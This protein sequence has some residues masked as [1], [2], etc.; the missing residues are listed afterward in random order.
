MPKYAMV[1]D[2]EKCTGCAACSVTCKNENNVP[3]G[4]FWSHYITETIGEFPNVKYNYITTLCNHCDNAPC[5][6]ACP[7]TPKA[8]T[9]ADNGITMHNAETCIGC[10]ACQ[11]ACPYGVIYYNTEEPFQ[12]WRSGDA[13]A[14]TEKVGGNVIPYY[15]P[16]RAATYAGIRGKLKVEKCTFCDHR[17]VNGEQPYCVDSC[18]AIARIF[19]DISDPDSE[20]SKLLKENEHMV[21]LP[22][23]NTKPNV[24]YIKKFDVK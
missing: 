4:I 13:A 5:V 7:I 10:R 11:V 6:E 24:Y 23:K 15:N 9:K 17:V 19:G 22:E 18:P 8:M 12:S 16:D 2:L 1:I 14:L 21:L 3:D 20:V